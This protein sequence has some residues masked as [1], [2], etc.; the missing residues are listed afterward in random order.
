MQC[1]TCS[2][3]VTRDSSN[4][5]QQSSMENTRTGLAINPYLRVSTLKS[6]DFRLSSQTIFNYWVRRLSSDSQL[7]CRIFTRAW[8]TSKLQVTCVFASLPAS[9]IIFH[10]FN[11][12]N[13]KPV[14]AQKCLLVCLSFY[15][16]KIL[17]KKSFRQ[18]NRIFHEGTDH[19]HFKPTRCAFPVNPT[20]PTTVFYQ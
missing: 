14:Y 15:S 18:L 3:L 4:R 8:V 16:L 5:T 12:R 6:D 19:A 7:K 20:R 17:S 1:R 10:Q 11:V 13:Y 9:D 2:K